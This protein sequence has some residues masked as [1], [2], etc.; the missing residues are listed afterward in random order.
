MRDAFGGTFLIKIIIVF[1]VIF[2]SFMAAAVQYAKAFRL[3]NGI[4]NLME[5]NS[6]NG[7]TGDPVIGDIQS[8]L[9]EG[10]YTGKANSCTGTKVVIEN[11]SNSYCY[12]EIEVIPK[13][14]S[15]YQV[16]TYL[17]ITLFNITYSIPI[18]G[19]TKVIYKKLEDEY[20]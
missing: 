16:T 9:K 7:E 11:T 13:I 1:I 6:F 12:E 18:T 4:I 19:E 17:S 3:K 10:N 5:I 15:Y 14:S 20:A 2:V 8:Y